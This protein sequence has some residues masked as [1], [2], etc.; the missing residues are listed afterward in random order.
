MHRSR[1]AHVQPLAQSIDLTSTAETQPPTIPNISWLP[2]RSPNRRSF[3]G[4]SGPFCASESEST[5]RREDGKA[6]GEAR[7]HFCFWRTKTKNISLGSEQKIRAVDADPVVGGWGR[8]ARETQVCFPPSRLP[9]DSCSLRASAR[10]NS[11]PAAR[12][13]RTIWPCD[14]TAASASGLRRGSPSGDSMG[15]VSAALAIQRLTSRARSGRRS[16]WLCRRRAR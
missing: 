11:K 7:A 10:A 8:A 4:G 16:C 5:G 1:T 12:G 2:I 14:G 15:C 9:V 3:R 6:Y 13:G